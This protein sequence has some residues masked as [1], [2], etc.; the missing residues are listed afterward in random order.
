MVG[1]LVEVVRVTK[2]GQITI[3]ES[4]MKKYGITNEI[5]VEETEGGLLLRRVPSPDDD[6]G[7]F[8]P[9]LKGKTSKQLLREAR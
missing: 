2:K 7:S 8:K 4:L 6:L 3:P 1:S 9:F 5:L